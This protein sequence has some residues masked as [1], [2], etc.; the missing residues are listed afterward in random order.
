MT[1]AEKLEEIRRAIMR[2]DLFRKFTEQGFWHAH[3]VDLDWRFNG[4]NIREEA[5]WLKEIWYALRP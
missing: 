4:E 2:S 1:D 3:C 5:D